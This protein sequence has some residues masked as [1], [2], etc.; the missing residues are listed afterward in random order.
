[1]I[2]IAAI[3]QRAVTAIAVAA[4]LAIFGLLLVATSAGELLGRR[5]AKVPP[6]FRPAPSDEEL[7]RRVIERYLAWGALATIFMALWLPAYWLREPTRLEDRGE[8]LNAFATYGHK[9]SA[10]RASGEQLFQ[11]FCV[12]CHGKEGAGTTTRFLIGGAMR[13]YA[14]PPLRFV[15]ARYG[16]TGASRAEI[17]QLVR[18]A[19]ERGRPGTPM[20]TW[21]LGFGGPFTPYHIDNLVLYI[22]AINED[23]DIADLRPG[24]GATGAEIFAANCA[25]CHGPTGEGSV[26]PNLQVALGRLTLDQLRE[27]IQKGRLNVNRPSM[28]SWAFFGDEA[29]A[30]LVAFIQSIQRAGA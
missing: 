10:E 28:P 30:K 13:D 29:I 12:R 7:E 6:G 8:Q 19:I 4:G 27:T 20:P 1:M 16:E 23:A 5:K 25:V 26:G 2:P 24:R 14:E 11:D 15:Y 22:Q 3:D 9:A 17:T 21:G 18:D